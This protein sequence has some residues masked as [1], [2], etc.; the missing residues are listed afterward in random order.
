M[1]YS[2][3]EEKLIKVLSIDCTIYRITK[4]SVDMKPFDYL[5]SRGTKPLFYFSVSSANSNVHQLL[6]GSIDENIDFFG[7]SGGTTRQ[8]RK[9]FHEKIRNTI[10]FGRLY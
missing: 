10:M 6:F 7:S 5:I 1:N 4:L 2:K 3:S 8:I 9:S